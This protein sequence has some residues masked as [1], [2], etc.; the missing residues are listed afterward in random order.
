MRRNPASAEAKVRLST[1]TRLVDAARRLLQQR[2][3]HG[4]GTA[5]ILALAEAPK[6]SMYHHFPE[7]KQ[8][9][10]AAAVARIGEDVLAVLRAA[11]TKREPV[12]A[13]IRRLAR[14]MAKWLKETNFRESTM[15]ASVSAC[16]DPTLPTLQT[17]LHDALATWRAE[18]TT[19]LIRD[20][21]SRAAAPGLSQTILAALEGALLT[22]RIERSERVVIEVAAQLARLVAL[23]QA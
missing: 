2:G 17:A 23:A 16:A 10:A 4:V 12:D 18:L 22:A 19:L 1:R 20:G 15:L 14:G 8:Q 9:I 6:G 5:E 11:D 21:V 3:Y 13:L 7:G